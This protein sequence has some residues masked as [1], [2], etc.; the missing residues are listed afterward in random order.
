MINF[1]EYPI[2]NNP[3]QT[4]GN[5]DPIHAMFVKIKQRRDSGEYQELPQKIEYNSEDVKSLEEFCKRYG[6]VG[7]SIGKM[8]PAVALKMLKNKMG[9]I[10]SPV[11]E[12][13]DNK[14][15]LLFG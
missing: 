7:F 3:L 2:I 6:I 5:Y 9:V 13:H 4:I 12:T 1:E 14:K 8:S 11:I 15:S 10:D